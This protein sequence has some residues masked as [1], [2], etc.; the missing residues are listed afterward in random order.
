VRTIVLIE[1]LIE[2]IDSGKDVSRRRL[3]RAIGS[4]ALAKMEKEWRAE[5]RSRGHKPTEIVEY[6]R[7]LGIAMRK[8]GLADLYSARRSPSAMK[9]AHAA[10][11]AFEDAYEYLVGALYAKP[12]LR[13]W[14]DRDVRPSVEGFSFDPSGMPFPVWSKNINCLG[15][16]LPKLRIRDFK[17]AALHEALERQE[18]RQRKHLEVPSVEPPTLGLSRHPL[19]LR[20]HDF[21]GFKF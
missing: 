9:L 7:R 17:R 4:T 16:G 6:G 14:L 1:E 20:S 18:S 12:D 2:R 13:M 8:Y 10:D 11:S 3:F 21:S 15:G 19:R 5:V